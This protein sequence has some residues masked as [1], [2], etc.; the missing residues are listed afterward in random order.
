MEKNRFSVIYT[1]LAIR[2]AEVSRGTE[3][4][5]TLVVRANQAINSG[6]EQDDNRQSVQTNY[7][8]MPTGE[9]GGTSSIV[10]E[11]AKAPQ[12]ASQKGCCVVF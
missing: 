3:L 12:T 2:E 5:P 8:A 11:Q 7:N 1:K 9:M 4:Q 10:R 6:P